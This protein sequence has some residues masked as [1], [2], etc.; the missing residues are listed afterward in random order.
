MKSDDLKAKIVN[1]AIQW[2]RGCMPLEA[3]EAAIDELFA[4]PSQ[5]MTFTNHA[6]ER[7]RSFGSLLDN[8]KEVFLKDEW[9]VIQLLNHN[10]KEAR[11]FQ[12]GSW[13]I[14]VCDDAVVTCYKKKANIWK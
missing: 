14:V 13:L 3:L 8:A 9:R 4:L 2:R 10:L 12:A 6:L 5:C 1:A 7:Y 11:Y